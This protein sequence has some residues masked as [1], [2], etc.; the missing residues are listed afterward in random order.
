M[1]K[2]NEVGK[3]G[4]DAAVKYLEGKGFVIR[5]RNW[6]YKHWELDIVAYKDGE[7]RVIEVKTRSD[8]D[9]KEP[10]EAVNNSKRM[11]LMKATDAYV[12]YF[13]LDVPVY[14]DI[15][16]LVGSDGYYKIEHVENA[17]NLRH[18]HY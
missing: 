3:A 1:A 9:F 13:N 15:I 4:E 10:I 7:V 17:F 16:T 14:F 18:Y 5:H 8:D 12:K 11:R 6:R 2:H